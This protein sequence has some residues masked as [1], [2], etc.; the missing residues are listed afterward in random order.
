MDE[1]ARPVWR[2]SARSTSAECCVEV[3]ALTAG[4]AL[5]DSKDPGGPVLHV[6]PAAFHQLTHAIRLGRYDH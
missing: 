2:R 5:R 1:S 4:P 6:S 3:A